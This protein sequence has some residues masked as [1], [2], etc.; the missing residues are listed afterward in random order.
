MLCVFMFVTTQNFNTVQKLS[1]VVLQPQKFS[2]PTCRC[3][4]WPA[5]KT[6]KGGKARCHVFTF[7][8]TYL[9]IQNLIW[10]RQW[11]IACDWYYLPC[12]LNKGRRLK[13]KG[14]A[15]KS[16]FFF[17]PWYTW[18]RKMSVFIFCCLYCLLLCSWNFT[19]WCIA[20]K[21]NVKSLP[22]QR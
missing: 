4:S 17:C 16:F 22:R 8:Q 11:T 5:L 1:H 19:N 12:L 21:R 9:E 18:A 15:D 2:F 3:F 10:K 14:G 6:D 13:C 7:Y 20:F